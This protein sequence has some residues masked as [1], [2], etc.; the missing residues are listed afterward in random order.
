LCFANKIK[1]GPIGLVAASG[2]GL[3]EVTVL[4]DQFGGGISQAIGVG[5]RDLSK[6]VM[7]RMTLH[8]INA[9]NADEETKIIV[10]I[11]KPPHKDVVKV[12]IEK[13]ETV[14]KEIVLCLL[15]SKL[16]LN[17]KHIHTTINLTET[18]VKAVTLLGFHPTNLLTLSNEDKSFIESERKLYQKDQSKLK[19]LFCGGTLAAE[20]LALI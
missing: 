1:R 9:L 12:L 4:I 13:L 20:A 2:T 15:D 11:S 8:A 18:A 19:A 10:I 14:N 5:G 7:G 3:Q 16:E 17:S 6:D